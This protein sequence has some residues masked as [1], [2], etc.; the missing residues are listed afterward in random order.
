MA[1]QKSANALPV[2]F[3]RHERLYRKALDSELNRWGKWIELR[4]DYEGYPGINV[5]EAALMGAGGSV[6]GH[7]I[8]CLDMPT[9]I[10]SVHHRILMLPET[11]QEA[12]WVWYVPRVNPDG[13]LREIGGKARLVGVSEEALRQRVHRAKNRILGIED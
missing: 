3:H 7:R 13:T 9:D 4:M 11:L 10:Y 12:I 1:T 5:L 2:D 6:P 8:L